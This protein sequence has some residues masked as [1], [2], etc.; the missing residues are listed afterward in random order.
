LVDREAWPGLLVTCPIWSFGTAPRSD[1][2]SMGVGR[3]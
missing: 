1:A 3:W 2:L